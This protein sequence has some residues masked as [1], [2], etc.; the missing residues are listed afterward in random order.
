VN[1]T[2]GDDAQD[3]GAD[4]RDQ[5]QGSFQEQISERE[6]KILIQN[7]EGERQRRMV[8]EELDRPRCIAAMQLTQV[9]RRHREDRQ[10][11]GPQRAA[12]PWLPARGGGQ[13]HHQPNE[14]VGQQLHARR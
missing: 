14:R 11:G 7:R 6:R 2:D 13:R 9:H 10:G 3:R 12:R 4:Q 1:R 8:T 5:R